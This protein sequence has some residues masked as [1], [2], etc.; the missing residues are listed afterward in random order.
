MSIASVSYIY[1]VY[2]QSM[3]CIQ[4]PNCRILH[5]TPHTRLLYDSCS[6]LA[7]KR[8]I[9]VDSFHIHRLH[10]PMPVIPIII[11]TTTRL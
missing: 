7:T 1:T 8:W 2:I 11:S 6:R 10:I 9:F 4:T 3:Y 5:T